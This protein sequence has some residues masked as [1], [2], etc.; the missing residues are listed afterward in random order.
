MKCPMCLEEVGILVM[1]NR[2]LVC[3]VCSEELHAKETED[4]YFENLDG[5]DLSDDYLADYLD[6]SDNPLMEDD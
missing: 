2:R 4:K 3:E 5:V 6:L 1:R